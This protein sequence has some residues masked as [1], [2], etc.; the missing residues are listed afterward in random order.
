MQEVK[1]KLPH[2]KRVQTEVFWYPAWLKQLQSA[3][4]QDRSIYDQMKTSK[5]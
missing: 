1:E 2:L 5:L 3:K 4:A